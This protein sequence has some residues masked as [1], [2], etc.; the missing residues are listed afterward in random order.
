MG[1]SKDFGRRAIALQLAQSGWSQKDISKKIGVDESTIV[2]WAKEDEWKTRKNAVRVTPQEIVNKNLLVIGMLLDFMERMNVTTETVLTYSKIVDQ[3]TKLSSVIEKIN[4]DKTSVVTTIDAF[5]EFSVWLE[6]YAE[7]TRGVSEKDI[8]KIN[9]LLDLYI[10]E[11]VK[12][13]E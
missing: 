10:Q 13:K 11:K 2:Q 4:K 1:S 9:G 6:S 7:K 12:S 8:D 3:I 5:D